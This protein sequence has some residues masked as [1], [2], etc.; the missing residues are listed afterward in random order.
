[1]AAV[2]RPLYV[3]IYHEERSRE[4]KQILFPLAFRCLFRGRAYALVRLARTPGHIHTIRPVLFLSI[5]SNELINGFHLLHILLLF[6]LLTLHHSVDCLLLM[7]ASVHV[8]NRL[9]TLFTPL[10]HCRANKKTMQISNWNIIRTF[11]RQFLHN[12]AQSVLRALLQNSEWHMRSRPSQREEEEETIFQQYLFVAQVI[13]LHWIAVAVAAFFNY[14]KT[15]RKHSLL[16]SV[17]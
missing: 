3:I 15:F 10:F 17:F 1:M 14:R 16:F 4:K 13:C 2:Y 8:H 9:L 12:S 6:L 11:Q 7:I 5:S